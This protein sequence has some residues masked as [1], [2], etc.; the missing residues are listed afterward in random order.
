[1]VK[2]NISCPVFLVI[3]LL[4]SRSCHEFIGQQ[5]MLVFHNYYEKKADWVIYILESLNFGC[6][7][8]ISLLNIHPLVSFVCEL[9]QATY[10]RSTW[11]IGNFSKVFWRKQISFSSH[12]SCLSA[13]SCVQELGL[14]L[15]K[16]IRPVESLKVILAKLNILLMAMVKVLLGCSTVK[17][18]KRKNFNLGS[19][20]W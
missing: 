20:H 13:D 7:H 2:I 8:N 14:W 1:M 11:R 18:Y 12:R 3:V 15:G 19:G 16:S 4:C 10:W 5:V 6:S 17:K 9:G